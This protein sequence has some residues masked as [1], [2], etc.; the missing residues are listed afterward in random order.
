MKYLEDRF[1]AVAAR[2]GVLR[3]SD[4][5]DVPPFSMNLSLSCRTPIR[6]DRSRFLTVQPRTVAGERDEIPQ[7]PLPRGRGSVWRATKLGFS[8]CASIFHESI[9]FMSHTHT[10]RPIP[11]PHRAAAHHSRRT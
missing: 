7:R 10:T 5:L 3:S 6:P 9:T 11:I 4:F 1:L 2:S 8:R